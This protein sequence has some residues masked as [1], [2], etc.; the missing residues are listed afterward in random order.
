[1]Q[2]ASAGSL[3][4]YLTQIPDPRGR[5][6][7]RFPLSAMLATVVCSVL[8]GARGYEAIAAWIHAQEPR[9]WYGLGYFRRPPC[10]NA[11]RN[12]L[13]SVDPAALEQAVRQWIREVL[14]APQAGELQAVAMDGKSLCGV[15]D[16]HG[17]TFHL[18]ALFDQQTGY[19][20]SQ[21]QVGD[22]TNEIKA[23]PELLRTLVLEGRVVTADAMLCQ[24]EIS[25]QIIDSGGHYLLVVKDNQPALKQALAAEFQPAFS[26]H[27]GA[28]T[29]S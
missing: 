10:A 11:F 26:P 17:R 23:A 19:V 8:S 4:E 1:V 20:L 18:L 2:P 12:L 7:R 6:G 29:A 13:M 24:R 15:L 3:L 28:A 9:V 14:P 5:Q 22:K 27:C 21:M 16:A 25:Q